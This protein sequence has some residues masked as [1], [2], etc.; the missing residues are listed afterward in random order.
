[1]RP[2]LFLDR[3]GVVNVD[4]GYVH[5]K[6]DFIFVNGIFSLVKAAREAGYLAVIVTNQAGI[7]RGYYSEEQ[8]HNLM[9]WAREQFRRHGGDLDAIYYCP[10][11]PEHGLARYK[12]DTD[13]RKP[14]PGMILRAAQEH[15]IDLPRSAMI[16]DS[17]KDMSAGKAA[18]VGTLF[19]FG[20][21]TCPEGAHKIF[22]LSEAERWFRCRS[23]HNV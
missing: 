16:G 21:E 4:K 13:M 17:Y 18:G 7:G 15:G 12:R 2:A 3:D 20:S 14:G 5:R 11:H 8:F 10:D 1:M 22:S 19:Y 6:E 23:A 9:D